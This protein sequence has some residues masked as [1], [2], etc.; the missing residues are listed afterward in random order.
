MLSTEASL[1]RQPIISRDDLSPLALGWGLHLQVPPLALGHAELPPWPPLAP[2]A[3]GH[4][5]LPSMSAHAYGATG[6]PAGQI[7]AMTGQGV[8]GEPHRCSL[9]MLEPH[10]VSMGSGTRAQP[11]DSSQSI[12]KAAPSLLVNAEVHKRIS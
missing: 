5:E 6:Q 4:A 1:V 10:T 12:S 8:T 7:R 3:L 11:Y 9:G 2:L